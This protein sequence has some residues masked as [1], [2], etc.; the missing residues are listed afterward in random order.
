MA[1]TGCLK[2]GH[3]QNLEVVNLEVTTLNGGTAAN[4]LNITPAAGADG[5]DDLATIVDDGLTSGSGLSITS[6]SAAKSTGGLLEVV[7]TNNTATQAAKTLVVASSGTGALAGAASFTS[8]VG[9]GNAVEI[10]AESLTTGSALNITATDTTSA[11]N[12]TG[13]ITM[14]GGATAPA[15]TGSKAGAVTINKQSGRITMHAADLGASAVVSFTLTNSCIND[16]SVIIVN[17]AAVGG[18][19]STPGSY[20]V[21]V[22]SVAD[23]SCQICLQNVTSSTLGEAVNIDFIVLTSTHS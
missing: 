10:S 21:F 20:N 9:E 15:Q 3:F 6:S 19:P 2:D 8:S 1:E 12:I 13:G 5:A 4:Q 17:T 14:A 16:G 11:L 22:D 18:V 23:G 7:Q